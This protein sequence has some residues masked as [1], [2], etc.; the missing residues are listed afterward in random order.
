MAR[1][2]KNAAIDVSVMSIIWASFLL[3]TTRYLGD[4]CRARRPHIHIGAL[5]AAIPWVK[6]PICGPAAPPRSPWPR[7]ASVVG[8]VGC[9][10]I[11]ELAKGRLAQCI[12]DQGEKSSLL[13]THVEPQPITE[14]VELGDRLDLLCVE[15]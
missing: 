12:L 4:H 7:A 14:Q 8:S 2:T 9:E 3:P 10:P 5:G 15:A 6:T 11:G 13:E 1:M